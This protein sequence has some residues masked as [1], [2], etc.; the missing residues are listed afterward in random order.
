MMNKTILLVVSFALMVQAQ[1]LNPAL[2]PAVKVGKTNISRSKIDS[3]A[4]M[5]GIQQMSQRAG[6]QVSADQIPPQAMQQLRWAMTE[7]LISTELLKL[8]AKALKT[9]VPKSRLD[10]AV[11]ALKAQFPSNQKFKEYLK[12]I[13]LSDKKFK[14]KINEQLVS[15]ALLASKMKKVTSPTDKEAKDWFKKNKDKLPVNDSIA[16]FRILMKK[17]ANATQNKDKKNFLDGLGAQVRLGKTPANA[18]PQMA[19][20]YSEEKGADKTGGVIKPFIAKS[21]GAEWVKAVKGLKLGGVTSAFETKEGIQIFFLARV[22]DGKYESYESEIKY[23]LSAEKEQGQ[24]MVVQ[25]YVKGLAKKYPVKY[26]D[27]AYK[28]PARAEATAPKK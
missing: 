28:A 22:N 20:Q 14:A 24:M 10:S 1:M 16:G 11:K 3:L 4:M 17:T 7:Q 26:L 21:K 13:G 9:K 2:A 8:E 23:M 5:V 25:K 12:K 6:K 19:A 15:D 18:F 27:L